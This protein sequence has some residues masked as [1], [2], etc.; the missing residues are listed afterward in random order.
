MRA[1]LDLCLVFLLSD[2]N[3]RVPRLLGHQFYAEMV[4]ELLHF[5]YL[6]IGDSDVRHEYILILKD[7]FSGYCFSR[8]FEHSNAANVADTLLQYFTTF[9]P[10]L[11]WFSDRG[12][13]F[14]NEVIQLLA[15][16][17]MVK[18]KFSTAYVPWS[19]GTVESVCK[20]V[21][22]LL[23][24]L[25]TEFNV[26]EARWPFLVASA[27]S[28]INN[29]PSRRLA[30]RA[31]LTVHAG[32]SPGSPLSV[33][34]STH[35]NNE[36]SSK[37]QVGIL[38]NVSVDSLLGSLDEMHKKVL[39][40][41]SKERSDAVRRHNTK[42]NVDTFNPSVGDYVVI[43]R[44]V[45]P[46]IFFYQMSRTSTHCRTQKRFYCGGGTFAHKEDF[47]YTREPYQALCRFFSGYC[48]SNGNYCYRYRSHLALY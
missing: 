31:P 20:E 5:D 8:S 24:V 18:H 6:F 10:V 27:Q 38:Q 46:R 28:V 40:S 35:G 36:V 12:S 22:R 2:G 33:T 34:L 1:F 43:S 25:G 30:V 45:G 9:R 16:S 13:H 7:D 41:L 3:A 17:F 44:P 19:N 39:G 4:G 14:C 23:R 32:Q 29:S 15:S 48:G 37:E 21:I 11:S 47:G 42:T 26:P